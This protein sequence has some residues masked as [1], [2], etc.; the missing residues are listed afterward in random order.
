MIDIHLNKEDDFSVKEYREIDRLQNSTVHTV[1][2]VHEKRVPIEIR[3][4]KSIHDA[5]GRYIRNSMT[6]GQFYEEAAILFMDINPP[7]NSA[8]ITVIRLE[9][10]DQ[11]LD[12]ALQEMIVLDVLTVFLERLRQIKG[13][14]HV[15]NKKNFRG[16]IKEYQKVKS[17]S[18]NLIKLMKEAKSYFG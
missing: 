13:V 10:K 9:N 6:H 14:I 8:P 2:T 12:D 15:S 1:H 17:P 4:R 3:M 16:I 5:V 18:D 11:S 7:L